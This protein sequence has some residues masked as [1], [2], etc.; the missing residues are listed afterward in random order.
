MN[1]SL[2]SSL[3]TA[4]DDAAGDAGSGSSSASG[5]TAAP[6]RGP[7]A[8][9]KGGG[10]WQ[11]GSGPAPLEAVYPQMAPLRVLERGQ[12]SKCRA[13]EEQ[14]EKQGLNSLLLHSIRALSAMWLGQGET[15]SRG[16]GP[17]IPPRF[18]V[19]RLCGLNRPFC[20]V[21]LCPVWGGGG[22]LEKAGCQNIKYIVF[23]KV[24]ENG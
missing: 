10:V 8:A 3:D 16:I 9:S 17:S 2:Q 1:A 5:R 6:T 7:K 19:S 11:P 22:S 13:P 12:L 20:P 4:G 18:L 23:Q 24:F 21:K 15:G 14:V